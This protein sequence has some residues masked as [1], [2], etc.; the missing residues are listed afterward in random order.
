MSLRMPSV[1]AK[2]TRA[3]PQSHVVTSRPVGG[4]PCIV[5]RTYSCAAERVPCLAIRNAAPSPILH[6][7]TR[8]RP[9]ALWQAEPVIAVIHSRVVFVFVWVQPTRGITG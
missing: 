3:S 1:V 4:K 8:V 7:A 9:G 6:L 5:H 2:E